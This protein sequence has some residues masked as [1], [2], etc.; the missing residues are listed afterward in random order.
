VHSTRYLEHA[1]IGPE[2]KGEKLRQGY[3]EI[4][5][6]PLLFSVGKEYFDS[7]Q[8]DSHAVHYILKRGERGVCTLVLC[9]LATVI[10]CID[11]SV[12][13]VTKSPKVGPLLIFSIS[14]G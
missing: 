11:T 14:L 12:Q 13:I 7:P 10:S 1:E 8:R 5:H 6:D 9:S 3:T 4:T 2:R